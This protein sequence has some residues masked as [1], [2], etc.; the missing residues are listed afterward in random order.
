MEAR[1]AKAY[2]SQKSVISTC[3]QHLGLGLNLAAI[4]DD[5]I[6]FPIWLSCRKVLAWAV[7]ST[8]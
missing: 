4:H 1:M 3:F 6:Q 7:E 8:C 2:V 5:H